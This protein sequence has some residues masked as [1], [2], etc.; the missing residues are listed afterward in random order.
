MCIFSDFEFLV[1]NINK[2][3]I[4]DILQ[5]FNRYDYVVKASYYDDEFAEDYKDRLEYFMNYI[6]I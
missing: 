2:T 6:N 4:S 3:N 5:T 1:E